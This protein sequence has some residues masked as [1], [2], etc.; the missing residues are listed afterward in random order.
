MSRPGPEA[1]LVERIRRALDET[2]PGIWTIKVHGGPYQTAG[3]P[4]LLNVLDGHLI[5]MEVK[6]QRLGESREHALA[7]VTPRQQA[8]ID[9]LNRAGATAGVVLSVEEA[10]SLVSQ[11]IT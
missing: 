8:T 4:D 7:R 6:A 9:A 3:V 10:I 1:L 2:Y 11:A 5:A